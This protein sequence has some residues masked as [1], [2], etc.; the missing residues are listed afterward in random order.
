MPAPGLPR[1]L[2]F[3]RTSIGE[4]RK[5]NSEGAVVTGLSPCLEAL[6][7]RAISEVASRS[8]RRQAVNLFVKAK[9]LGSAEHTIICDNPKRALE[10]EKDEKATGCE[11]WVEDGN[12][13]RI[14]DAGLNDMAERERAKVE[15]QPEQ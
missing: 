10:I 14:D 13:K 12:G 1:L 8:L 5:P 6:S 11:V 3:G 7:G 15:V 9:D 2:Q 4:R